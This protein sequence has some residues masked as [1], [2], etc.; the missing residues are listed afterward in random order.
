M[1]LK[2]YNNHCWAKWAFLKDINWLDVTFPKLT[3]VHNSRLY[4][5]ADFKFHLFGALNSFYIKISKFFF[6][7]SVAVISFS[8]KDNL[9]LNL[10]ALL[11]DPLY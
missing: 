11:E 1:I 8:D 5:H 3:K 10:T 2:V 7:L 6:N 9:G 4:V